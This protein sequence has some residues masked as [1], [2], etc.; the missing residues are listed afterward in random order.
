[1]K[2][3]SALA[4]ACAKAGDVLVWDV[5]K[6]E[7][8]AWVA[9]RFRERGVEIERDACAVLVDIVGEDKL[10]LALEIDKLATWAAGEPL[11]VEEVQRLATPSP[12]SRR[13]R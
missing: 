3:D 1:M 7:L 4:K 11:G 2:K 9:E 5:D 12:T 8:G 6:Q 13:G 10:A